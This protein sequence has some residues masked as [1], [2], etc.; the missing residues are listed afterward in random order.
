MQV[1][2]KLRGGLNVS[3]LLDTQIGGVRA[4]PDFLPRA[5]FPKELGPVRSM[6]ESKQQLAGNA[7]P[8]A[9]RSCTIRDN[10]GRSRRRRS[11]RC[12]PVLTTDRPGTSK[13]EQIGGYQRCPCE[14]TW[15]SARQAR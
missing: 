14:P 5:N 1:N 10:R 7:R 8:I 15:L 9:P 12:S 11:R 2:P 3:R 13:G 4:I 6:A